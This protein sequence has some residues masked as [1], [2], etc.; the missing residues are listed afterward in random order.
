MY[1]TTLEVA[2]FVNEIKLAVIRSTCYYNLLSFL[3]DHLTA[4]LWIL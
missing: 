4:F 3:M 1:A 2:I